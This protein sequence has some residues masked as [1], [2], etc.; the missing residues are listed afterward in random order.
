MK[1]ILVIKLSSL[2]DLA[3][4]LPAVHALG[5][6]TGAAIDWVVQPEYASLV[7]AVPGVE[8]TIEFPRRNAVR[9]GWKFLRELRRERYDAVVDL[10]GLLKSAIVSRLARGAVRYGPAWAREGS[11]IF[12]DV[13][14]AKRSGSR[15]HAVAELL[16]VV[17][18]VAERSVNESVPPA[19]RFAGAATGGAS[20]PRVAIAPFSRWETKNWPL[21]RFAELG[22]RLVAE[23]GCEI[24]IVGGA[25][26]AEQGE[27][28][29]RL[30]GEAARSL[31]GKTDLPGMCSLLKS[32]DLLVT[33]DS[34]PMHWADAMGVPLVA[35]FGST[36]PGRTGPYHQLDHVVVRRDLECR[37]CHS[38]RCARNDMAC[39]RTLEVESVFR[40]AMG[41][42]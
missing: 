1:R 16:D 12:Y 39:L 13:R 9:A 36:D 7:R 2:G 20:G 4:A 34:G 42:L 29:A 5:E 23:M 28:L 24:R 8:R 38:R 26:D 40:A 35:I 6:R 41:V 31:C 14:P 3:H 18:R 21:D 37:P 33:V 19:P 25:G 27:A 22:R 15:A 30:I 32:M 11:H 17:D 10:Q